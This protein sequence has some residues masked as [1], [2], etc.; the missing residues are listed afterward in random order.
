MQHNEI[1]LLTKYREIIRHD[2]AERKKLILK[3][4]EEISKTKIKEQEK[5]CKILRDSINANIKMTLEY[6]DKIE[7]NLKNLLKRW[8]NNFD[9]NVEE[10]IQKLKTELLE[11]FQIFVPLFDLSNFYI[12][13][14]EINEKC[15]L[16]GSILKEEVSTINA[17]QIEELQRQIKI[18]QNEFEEEEIRELAC[19]KARETEM[20]R[21]SEEILLLEKQLGALSMPHYEHP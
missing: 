4:E 3:C 9:Y 6:I 10:N 19:I 7:N 15:Q 14:Q 13:E 2:L 16:D 20:T 8:P 12:N 18:L 11:R 5:K 17:I 21:L 1:V